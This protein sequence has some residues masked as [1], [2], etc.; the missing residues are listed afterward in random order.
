LLEGLNVPTNEDQANEYW[1]YR[2]VHLSHINLVWQVWEIGRIH[3]K[4][5]KLEQCYAGWE[6]FAKKI[7]ATPLYNASLATG[8]DAEKPEIKAGADLWKGMSSID[9]RN[10]MSNYEA[11]HPKFFDWLKSLLDV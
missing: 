1:T 7:I 4:G 11:V 5:R 9:I 10:G 8:T 3:G 6:R 2:G